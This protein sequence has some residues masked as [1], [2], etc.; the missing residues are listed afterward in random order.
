MLWLPQ[1]SQVVIKIDDIAGGLGVINAFAGPQINDSR[2]ACSPKFR[3]NAWLQPQ[4][5][6]QSKYRLAITCT[7]VSWKRY[8]VP[9]T[10]DTCEIA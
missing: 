3:D 2:N 4:M 10:R 8:D 5:E 9:D 7:V 6:Y 1:S